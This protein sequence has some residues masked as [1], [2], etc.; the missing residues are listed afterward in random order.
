MEPITLPN[1]DLFR[2]DHQKE[3]LEYLSR[4]DP[5]LLV[6]AWPC[7]D[8]SPLQEFGKKTADQMTRLGERIQ[9]SRILLR[10]VKK[11]AKDQRRR[12]G[13]LLG[14]NPSRSKAWL[15]PDIEEAFEGTG[16]TITDMCR[17]NLKKPNEE[18]PEEPPQC[19][20]K[21]TRLRGTPEIL[22]Y[23]SRKCDGKHHQHTPVL[24]G[25]KIK[26]KWQALSEFAGG[27]TRAF[28]IRVLRGAEDYLKKG[29]VQETF[30]VNETFPEERL[31][32]M[33]D[34]EEE[35]EEVGRY[36]DDEEEQRS[37]K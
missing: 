2:S 5:D 4:A 37:R 1:W 7:C 14:E 13:A 19:M 10:F 26:G 16:S 29:R 30:I 31:E 22:K 36:E 28:A 6:I 9:K 25:V 8:W 21:R 33:E 15:E 32:A 20:R 35:D 18:F 17:Y 3:A 12:G 34:L 11:A 27:Y 24:G 23:C